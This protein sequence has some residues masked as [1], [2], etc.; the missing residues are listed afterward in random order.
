MITDFF[1]STAVVK[2]ETTSANS[3]GG[4]KRTFTTRIASLPCRLAIKHNQEDII[5]V[6]QYGKRTVRKI[7]RLTCAYS[8]ANNAIEET[9]RVTADGK[10]YEIT[11]KY[12][13][14]L[15]NRHL[16]I[17]LLEVR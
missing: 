13:P 3:I 15:L 4:V 2:Q 10:E 9:D 1:N 12:N 7:W 8:A 5:E 11:G 14:G 16:E 17:D 6:D